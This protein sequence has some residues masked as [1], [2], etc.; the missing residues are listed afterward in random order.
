MIHHLKLL[1]HRTYVLFFLLLG[2]SSQSIAQEQLSARD[3][4]VDNFPTVKGDL[5]VRNPNGISTENVRFTESDSE[6]EIKPKFTGKPKAA[7]YPKDQ[8][9]AVIFLVLNPGSYGKAELEWYKAVIKSAVNTGGVIQKGDKVE[10]F[11]YNHSSNGQIVYPANPSFTDDVS[12]I[13]KKL[14]QLDARGF[15]NLCSSQDLFLT[16]Q[17]INHTLDILEKQNLKIPTAIY[18]LGDDKNCTSETDGTENAG[19]RSL[20]LNIP[21][22]AVIKPRASTP[23]QTIQTLCEKTHG[24]YHIESDLTAGSNRLRDYINSMLK[25][26]AGLLYS[27]E[28]TSGIKKD[29]NNHNI[30]IKTFGNNASASG[31]FVLT[32]PRRNPIEWMIDNPLW[33]VIILLIIGGLTALFLVWKKNNEKKR[34]EDLRRH[35]MDKQAL[36]ERQKQAEEASQRAKDDLNKQIDRQKDALSAMQQQQRDR[37][38]QEMRQRQSEE[39]KAANASLL[40]LMKAKGNLPWFDYVIPGPQSNRYEITKPK[41]VVG[42]GDGV[43]LRINV[44]T[45]SKRHFEFWFTKQGEYWVKDLGS[46]NGLYVNGKKV[47]QTTL[48]HGDFIQAGEVVFNFYI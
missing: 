47:S 37:E 23:R 48:R 18:L 24:L 5:W 38:L 22:Y 26:N 14:D 28:Y 29:G 32:V 20:R 40:S 8:K 25:R 35:E 16:W 2:I 43:D 33:S 1:L 31:E 9:K 4:N 42:R 3:L 17:A 10:I 41:L 21:I 46:S 39:E 45:M 15:T 19:A 34:A 12:A 11:N 30:K 27:F 6:D 13:N 36:Q 44:P 7:S